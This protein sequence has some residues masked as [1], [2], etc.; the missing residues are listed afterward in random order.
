MK[1]IPP[2]TKWQTGDSSKVPK[3]W[4]LYA[5]TPINIL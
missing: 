2:E 1:V 5:L 3:Y 4:R